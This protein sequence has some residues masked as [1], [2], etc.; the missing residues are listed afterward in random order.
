MGVFAVFLD[1]DGTLNEDPGYLGDPNIV[2]LLPGTGEA[3]SLLKN[4]LGF[5]LIVVSNQSGISR[6]LISTDMVNAVNNRINELLKV[7]NVAID[8]FYYCPYHPEFSS[9]EESSCRKPSPQMVFQAAKDFSI[10]L[11]G[12]YFVGDSASDVEC[13]INAGVK[14]ILVKTGYGMDSFSV[15]IKQNNFPTFVAQNILEVSSIIKK[16]KMEKT[17]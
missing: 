2:K 8:A 7:Y 1:R 4:E 3:L 9:E 11:K 14:T 6:G 10:D 16:D 15:L 5:K 12:S 17:N 13:G